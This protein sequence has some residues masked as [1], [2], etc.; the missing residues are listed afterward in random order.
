[1]FNFAPGCTKRCFV[2]GLQRLVFG[3]ASLL[4]MLSAAADVGSLGVKVQ[5]AV[6]NLGLAGLRVDAYEKLADGTQQWVA[7]RDTDGTGLAT[8]DL[9]GLG[10]GRVYVFKT[11]PYGLQV[12]SAE[13]SQT[14]WYTFKVGQLQVQVLDGQTG[15]AK[16]GQSIQIKRWEASGSHTYLLTATTD[17]QG[18]IKVDP[19]AVGVEPYIATALSPTDGYWKE[20]EKYWNKGPHTFV[21]GNAAIV[22]KVVDG[23][24]GGVLSGKKVEAKEKQADGSL[25]LKLTRWTDSAGLAKFDL[26]GVG[27]GKT[28]VLETQPYL[29][30]VTSGDVVTAGEKELRA[31]KLQVTV[32]NGMTGAVY[33]WKAVTLQEKKADGSYAWQGDFTADGAGQVRLD[34]AELGVKNYVL[35]ATSA[36]DG[37]DK[38]SE[39]YSQGGSYQFKV[40]GA[41]LYVKVQD[42]VSNLGLAGLRV[43]AYEKLADGTQQWVAKRDT[44]GTGLAKF[45]LEGLGTGKVYVFK[46]TPYGLQVTSAEQSQTG[47]YTFKVGQLQV[48]VLDGQTGQA[49]AGQSIQVKRWEASGSHTYLLT[50][51][52][53][54][55][56]WIKVDPPAVGVEPYIATALSP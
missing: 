14:G 41:G 11:N 1:M 46:V 50:A 2:R 25:L 21:L 51:T 45:D 37:T 47:W 18:W 43:D 12:T 19:P 34:P 48:Q 7:K 39:V 26:D 44:D 53:D 54:G 6:S 38:F 23:V 10:T 15:Q 9:E 29:Q 49:K 42:A 17:G 32:L 13:Q 3:L 24:S 31:G 5:D 52:T 27:S 33:P 35:R 56:G 20:S 55:Q 40:G 4:W 36:M 22:A 30:K 28:Y 16:A 8:F